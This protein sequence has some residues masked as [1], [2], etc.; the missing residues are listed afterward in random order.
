MQVNVEKYH[1][2]IQLVA[3]L[4]VISLNSWQWPSNSVYYQLALSRHSS[5]L[6]K[7]QDV[8]IAACLKPACCAGECRE[9]P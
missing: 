3:E 1:E 8:R 7:F 5:T 9:V 4:T 6:E 2:W